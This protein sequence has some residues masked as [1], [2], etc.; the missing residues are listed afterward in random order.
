MQVDAHASV[1]CVMPLMT[2]DVVL[3]CTT[4]VKGCHSSL[5]AVADLHCV[6]ICRSQAGATSQ[7][8][9]A[10]ICC[11]FCLMLDT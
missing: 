4:P 10:R 11:A 8:Q 1:Q 9:T 6:H 2:P 5:Q 3:D 7:Q